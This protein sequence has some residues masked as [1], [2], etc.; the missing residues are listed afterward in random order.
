MTWSKNLDAPPP[1]PTA[2]TSTGTL[3]ITGT[4]QGGG[5]PAAGTGSITIDGQE[6]SVYKCDDS[7]RNCHTVYDTG[8]VSITAN[9][10]TDSRNYGRSD[11][12]STIASGL[13]TL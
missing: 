7:G 13:A 5:S 11:T 8:T 10:H 9:G 6:Q 3:T 1:G 4:E 12:P 2:T